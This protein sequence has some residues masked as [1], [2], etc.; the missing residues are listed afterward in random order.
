VG[1]AAAHLGGRPET[2]L[3]GSALWSLALLL[4]ADVLSRCATTCLGL[5]RH[6]ASPG[7]ALLIAGLA[8]A[9]D[10]FSVFAG[11]TKALVE[12][13]TPPLG[14]LL[15][16]LPTFSSSLAHALSGCPEVGGS[17][18]GSCAGRGRTGRSCAAGGYG[19]RCADGRRES[20]DFIPCAD[21]LGL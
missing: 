14:Y 15:L 21:V 2:L 8:T 7:V 10:P 9:A 20:G 19:W 4:F 17:S 1:V 3:E 16:G 13:G 12:R 6:V 18:G 11:I 5:A